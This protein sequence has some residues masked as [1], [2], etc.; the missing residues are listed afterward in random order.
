MGSQSLDRLTASERCLQ[1]SFM[2]QI[3]KCPS[4][5]KGQQ[6]MTTMCNMLAQFSRDNSPPK[7]QRHQ[8]LNDCEYYAKSHSICDS[9]PHMQTELIV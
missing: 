5:S 4:R 7:E 1:V 3:S 6:E 2:H 9:W 8:V